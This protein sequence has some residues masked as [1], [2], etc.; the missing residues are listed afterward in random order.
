MLQSSVLTPL[1]AECG[2]VSMQGSVKIK[3]KGR[4]GG[5][6]R[7]ELTVTGRYTGGRGERQKVQ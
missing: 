7:L 4:D 2:A 3:L 6:G 1:H 5:G